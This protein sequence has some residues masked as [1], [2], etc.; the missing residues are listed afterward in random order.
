M[1]SIAR[2]AATTRSLA[3]CLAIL[4]ATAPD[5]AIVAAK[6]SA[7]AVQ[8]GSTG[9][10]EVTFDRRVCL[11]SP[12]NPSLLQV[13]NGRMTRLV[14]ARLDGTRISLVVAAISAD[15]V[16]AC[17]AGNTATF[18][19]PKLSAGTYTVRVAEANYK[20]VPN[21][22]ATFQIASVAAVDSTLTVTPAATPIPVYVIQRDFG[23]SLITEDVGTYQVWPTFASEFAAWQPVFYAWPVGAAGAAPGLRAVEPL[24]VTSGPRTGQGFYTVDAAEK[25]ALLRDGFFTPQ[26]PIFAA[27]VPE[28]GVCADGHVGIYRAFDAK[29]LIHR[30]V[31]ASTYRTMIANG[32]IGEGIAFC[33]A[34]GP[35]GQ[36][37]W[38]PN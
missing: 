24:T 21:L 35:A 27:F 10:V 2:F 8:E 3:G 20:F 11:P 16:S 4:F 26:P 18:A 17:E 29:A 25:E 5:A 38:A 37:D 1:R 36:S 28:G 34:A 13:V 30:F 12:A 19:L 32:W 22:Y 9:Y 6:L 31:P 33:A 14:Q 23:T 7:P 15:T